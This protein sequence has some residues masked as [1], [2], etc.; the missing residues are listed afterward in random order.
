M[1]LTH[2][3]LLVNIVPIDVI[4]LQTIPVT[5]FI[6]QLISRRLEI[7]TFL[8]L[9]F[10]SLIYVFGLLI[11]GLTIALFTWQIAENQSPLI[12][13]YVRQQPFDAYW[14]I[15]ILIGLALPWVLFLSNNRQVNRTQVD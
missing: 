3:F 4:L 15:F 9:A 13:E 11:V 12:P 2:R 10:F 5:A 1:F 8:L 6:I 7:Y 14:T